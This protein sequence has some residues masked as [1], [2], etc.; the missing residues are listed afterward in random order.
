MEKNLTTVSGKMSRAHSHP[1]EGMTSKLSSKQLSELKKKGSRC[2]RLRITDGQKRT[3]IWETDSAWLTEFSTLNTG[4]SPNVAQE[5]TLSQILM[6]EVPEKYYLSPKACLGILRRA[7]ARGKELPEV[8]KKALE[9]QAD[10]LTL[11]VVT[12]GTA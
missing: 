3:Y 1:T 2:L 10:G 12:D 5:S 8:L 11:E 9:R 7:S 6:A 4:A